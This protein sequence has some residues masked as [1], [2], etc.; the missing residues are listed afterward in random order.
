[1]HK[2][3]ESFQGD[4]YSNGRGA[5]AQV[6]QPRERAKYIKLKSLIRDG[7]NEAPRWTQKPLTVFQKLHKIRN[8]LDHV[9][10]N[11][12]IK[13]AP[14]RNGLSKRFPASDIVDILNF[15]FVNSRVALVELAQMLG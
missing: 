11:D 5:P 13:H 7:E 4:V 9:R 15:C 8:M 14:F 12:E 10:R 2:N 6:S 3:P 1:M